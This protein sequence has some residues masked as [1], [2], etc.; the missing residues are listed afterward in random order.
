MRTFSPDD[1]KALRAALDRRVASAAAWLETN[2]GR[3][4]IVKSDYKQYWSLP[5]GLIDAGETP[6]QAVRREVAEEIGIDL[7]VESFEFRMVISRVSSN[8]GMS[9][10]FVFR[11]TIADNLLD[12]TRL[13]EDEIKELAYVSR[14]EVRHNDRNFAEAIYAWATSQTGYAEHRLP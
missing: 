12:T 11:A 3:L 13:Q 6:L 5:G 7:P 8:L 2:D 4:I 10:Q 14:E 9:Y 1:D